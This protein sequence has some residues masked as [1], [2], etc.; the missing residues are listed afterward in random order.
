MAWWQWLLLGF[1]LSVLEL[2]TP[3]GFYLIFFGIGA[4]FVGLVSLIGFNV[5]PW[6][7]WLAFSIAS[8]VMLVLFRRRIVHL[9]QPGSG[10]VDSLVGE[11]AMTLETIKPGAIGRAELRGTVWSARNAHDVEMGRGERARVERIDGLTLYLVPD[12]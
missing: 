8:V 7:E 12:R 1:A 4:I 9:M 6:A 2:A 5:P 10:D 11:M 3:G